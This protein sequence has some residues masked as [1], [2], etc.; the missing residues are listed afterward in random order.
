MKAAVWHGGADIRV[1]EIPAPSIGADEVLV[2]VAYVGVCG[3]DLHLM[4]G[5]LVNP[6][7]VFGHE[8]SGVIEAKGDNVRAF[9]EGDRVV[10]HPWCPCGEC[11]SC[12]SGKQNL[13]RTPVKILSRGEG[14]FAEYT[15][16]KDKSVFL[17]P[18]DVDLAKAALVEPLSIAVHAV[19]L[20]GV[21]PGAFVVVIGSGAIGLLC[22]KVVQHVGA[23]AVAVVEPSACR[24]RFARLLGADWVVAP[25]EIRGIVDEATQGAGADVCIEA[26]GATAAVEQAVQLVRPGGRVVIA[27]WAPP[28]ASVSLKPAYLYRYEVGIQGSFWST[29]LDYLTAINLL[30]TWGNELEPIVKVFEGLESLPEAVRTMRNREVVKPLVKIA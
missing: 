1:E 8:F 16:V 13:C 6:P 28:D 10:V 7:A 15:A 21:R 20:A 12:R 14:G 18:E 19:D 30:R 26:V 5:W 27:G 22:L 9:S 2:R 25:E 23:R 3:S 24:Q 4:D 29:Y 11:A 17:L